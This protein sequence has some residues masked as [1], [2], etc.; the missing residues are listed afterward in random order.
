MLSFHN[1]APRFCDGLTRRNFL[2][3]GAMGM[4]G[5]TLADVLRAES[6]G[7]SS[8]GRNKSTIMIYLAGGPSHIDTYDPKPDAPAEYRGEFQ[9]IEGNVPGMTFA[10]HYPLQAQIADKLVLVRSVVGAVSEHA[11][12]LL[13]SGYGE[14]QSIQQGGRPGLGAILSKLLGP[15]DGGVPPYV[16]FMGNPIGTDSGYVGAAHRPFTPDNEGMMNLTLNSS[17]PLARLDERKE[18]LKVFDR[19]RHDVDASG[20][21][22]GMDAFA[23]RAFEI[24]TA[25]KTRDALDLELEDPR[26]REMY[27]L[28]N[29]AAENFLKARRLIEAGVRCVTLAIGS[30]DT[31]G[32][33]FGHLRSQMPYVDRAVSA[34]VNDLHQRGLDQD[35]SVVMWGEFGRT[36]RVNS[37]AGRDHWEP[38]MSALL[39]GGGFRTGQVIGSTNER[40]E[41]AKDRPVRVQQ[42]LSTIYHG[43]GVDPST[44]IIDRRGRPMYLLDDREPI[45]ELI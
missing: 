41:Y 1:R 24:I 25:P 8:Q 40:G 31:H 17:V 16:S 38:V 14:G 7:T 45:Q 4:G 32:N 26:V 35:C 2:Q 20:S 19:I 10:E 18:L 29:G 44:T 3:I 12:S 43:L 15:V 34:L 42:I 9:T 23:S 28:N 11:S 30:W 6:S 36:P 27:G 21:M 33:N 22:N 5:L 37:G 39:A 13:M